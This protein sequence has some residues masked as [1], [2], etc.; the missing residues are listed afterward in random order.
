[1]DIVV[2]IPRSEYTNDDKE[3]N[4]LLEDKERV[5]FWTL[6]VKPK[7][8]E[9]GDRVYFV[10]N[11]VI[12]SSMRVIEIKESSSTKCETTKRVWKGKC[13][14]FMDHYRL[15]KPVST[16]GFRGFAYLKNLF[17]YMIKYE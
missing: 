12:H 2:I 14:I 11:G 6:P 16:H 17:P 9:V 7:H 4:D 8:L 13:Q 1:M 10:R 5:A 3:L 15:E